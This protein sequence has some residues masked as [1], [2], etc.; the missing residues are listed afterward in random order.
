[1]GTFVLIKFKV[2]E[3][4]NAFYIS[5]ADKLVSKLPNIL[6]NYG[7]SFVYNFYLSKGVIPESFSF[8]VVSE[9]KVLKYLNKLSPAKATG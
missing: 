2:A 4:F 6:I 1:M 8:S 9:S 3:T 5:V 7:T